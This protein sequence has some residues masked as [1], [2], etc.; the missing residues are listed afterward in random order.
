[1]TRKKSYTSGPTLYDLMAWIQVLEKKYECTVMLFCAPRTRPRGAV[2]CIC[3]LVITFPNMGVL[4]RWTIYREQPAV[5]HGTG[6]IE[7][8]WLRCMISADTEL[9]YSN[10]ARFWLRP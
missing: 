1:M 4:E 9:D 10:Q 2:E 8:A 7:A 5:R 3:S 6:A